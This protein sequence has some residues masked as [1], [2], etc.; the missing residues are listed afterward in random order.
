MK[1]VL[2]LAI[3]CSLLSACSI[4]EL[5]SLPSSSNK[6]GVNLEEKEQVYE[7]YSP[8]DLNIT[9][10]GDSL[11]EGVGDHTKKGGY[12]PLLI[13]L[14][15]DEPAIKDIHLTQNG[16]R[17]LTSTELIPK[18]Q[19]KGAVHSIKNADIVLITIGGNDVMDVVRNHYTHIKTA[20]FN[21]G[22]AQ[23]EKNVRTVLSFIREQNKDADIYL[24]GL[25]NPFQKW[26]ANIDEFGEILKKWNGKSKEIVGSYKNAYYVGISDL[27]EK[28]TE[29]LIY[30]EDSFH[31]NTDGY[32][33]IADSVYRSIKKHSIPAVEK[34]A[35]N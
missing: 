15:E 32:D 34:E 10:I 17:G 19:T 14:L 35:E 30:E 4:K 6:R 7:H 2:L 26:L 18:I 20:H 28:N 1:K 3:I 33:K 8:V 22:L 31:P 29:H 21:E 27:F 23:Y 13:N 9:A 5:T 24:I 25:Y 16:K 11:T 12:P